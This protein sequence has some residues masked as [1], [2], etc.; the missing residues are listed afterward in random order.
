M[1]KKA[2]LAAVKELILPELALMR[3]ELTEV[4]SGLALTNKRID[5]LF[6]I[7][8]DQSR[9]IDSLRDELKADNLALRDEFKADNLALRDE[10]K[11]DI[12]ET[13]RRLDLFRAEVH[14]EFVQTNTHIHSRL[15]RLYEVIVRR[16]EHQSLERKVEQLE[17]R[18]AAAEQRR[19]T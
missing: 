2:V 19:L 12:A 7:V 1:L 16:E 9:R 11:A 6:A 13:N 8:H 18:L 5:D 10:L 15:D 14:A 17:E 3:Q 4:K